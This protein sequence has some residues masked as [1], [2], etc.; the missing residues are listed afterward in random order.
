MVTFPERKRGIEEHPSNSMHGFYFLTMAILL[1]VAAIVYGDWFYLLLWP[2]LSFGYVSL[3]Y[4]YLGTR[5]FGKRPNG[6]LAWG[7]VLFL[8][9]FYLCVWSV[10]HTVRLIS[11]ESKVDRV[12]EN[13]FVSRR[14][15]SHE[16]PNEVATVI[17]LTCEFPEAQALRSAPNYLSLPILDAGAMEPADLVATIKNI[18]AMEGPIL[19]HCAQGHGR[20]GLMAA[21]FLV[22]DGS[23]TSAEAALEMLQAKRPKISVH[24]GQRAALEAAVELLQTDS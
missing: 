20:T 13:L 17:D 14:L 18:I 11:A 21:L 19:I 3:G 10:W 9:P 1:T 12:H 2:A 6:T 23:A 16:L 5:V 15:L 24:P 4:F 8:L 7:T 22:A